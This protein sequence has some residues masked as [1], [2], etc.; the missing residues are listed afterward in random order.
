MKPNPRNG[1]ENGT[2]FP[3]I[4]SV[5]FRHLGQVVLDW[6]K[7]FGFP[8]LPIIIA[9][10]ILFSPVLLSGQALYWG[11]P[12]LQFVPWRSLAFNILK[13]GSLPLWNPMVG[14]GAPLMANYQS[15]LF[16]PA[17]WFLFALEA[18]GGTVLMAWGQTLVVVFH[19][20]LAGTGM[21]LLCRNLHL[22][23]F[24]QTIGGLAFSLSG[25]LVARVGFL[26]IN[27][28]VAWL[29]WII[30][31]ANRIV[32]P[33]GTY[34]TTEKSNLVKTTF[35]LIGCLVL[36][37]LAGHAQTTYYT[38]MLLTGW[39]VLW[40]FRAGKLRGALKASGYLVFALAVAVMI[41]AVQIVP[42]A[43]YLLQSQRASSVT[44]DIAT[45]YSFFPLRFL[46]LLAP[47][48]FGSPA[49]GNYLLPSDNYWEDAVYI[50]FIPLALAIGGF[51]H[52]VRL[53]FDGKRDDSGFPPRI[54][55]TLAI[56]LLVAIVISFTIAL[57]KNLPVFPF[58]YQFVPTFNLF[59][60]P[61]R[62][63]IISIFGLALL[64]AIGAHGW[65]R[66]EGR[67]RAWTRRGIAISIAIF[68][69]LGSGLLVLTGDITIFVKA[70]AIAGGLGLITGFMSMYHPTGRGRWNAIWSLLVVLIIALD[71]LSAGWGLNP[72]ITTDLYSNQPSTVVQT[73]GLIQGDRVYLD[74]KSEDALK[75]DHF[76]LFDNFYNNPQVKDLRAAMLPDSNI[77]VGIP[78]VN[79]FDPFVPGRYARWMDFLESA[80]ADVR[81][82]MLGL[83]NVGI[84]ET[85]DENVQAEISF[86][87]VQSN[88]ATWTSCA[89]SALNEQD[90]WEKTVSWLQ[91]TRSDSPGS[92]IVIEGTTV[93]VSSGCTARG[94][95]SISSLS[96]KAD[97]ITIKLATDEQGWL[98]IPD[99]WY[100]GWKAS[101]DGQE[102]PVLRA[103]YMFMAI[104]LPQ[105]AHTIEFLYRPPS[106]YLGALLSGVGILLAVLAFILEKSK[107]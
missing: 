73:K 39:I 76:F 35:P 62:M 66:P 100:P 28:A 6:L 20:I 32:G 22:N 59:Q 72:G 54:L 38:I 104:A 89:V 60:A 56:F 50:G 75:F 78:S 83:M 102:T 91:N 86:T 80:A 57:G 29:P 42:T 3:L 94:N 105:G 19:L 82:R 25:Y 40:G 48:L 79:N 99:T 36:Q 92:Q 63:T 53:R 96:Q 70:L 41:T 55:R 88:Q 51:W 46:T 12:Y 68:L 16:Y 21:A 7:S 67:A 10:V 26:S 106:F 2:H 103:D 23:K 93:D 61:T 49:Q 65:T 33:Q 37:L 14:M 71:L 27:A 8:Y 47:N 74:P 24:S 101:I 45:N 15:A 98:M 84:L 13:S 58:L 90:A 77:L 34:A 64:A 97:Q 31:A 43:E 85:Y 11:T 69:G 4:N 18:I 17:T 44:Y 81:A 5:F 95:F 107:M 9:P 1:V 87:R 52:S 30:L